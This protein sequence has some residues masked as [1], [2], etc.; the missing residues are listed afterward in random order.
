MGNFEYK[1]TL[2][3]EDFD[4]D[5]VPVKFTFHHKEKFPGG[6]V[7][8]F[9]ES[10]GDDENESYLEAFYTATSKL[11]EGEPMDSVKAGTW[12]TTEEDCVLFCRHLNEKINS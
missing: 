4:E 12:F 2:W 8:G 6:M 10:E 11:Y 3:R 9:Y 7:V 1:Q 5:F